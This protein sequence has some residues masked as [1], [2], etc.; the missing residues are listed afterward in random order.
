MASYYNALFDGRSEGNVLEQDLAGVEFDRSAIICAS[1]CCGRARMKQS[2]PTSHGTIKH[3]D[4]TPLRIVAK[5]IIQ[6]AGRAAAWSAYIAQAPR[7]CIGH[8]ITSP[9]RGAVMVR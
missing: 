3:P 8:E 6:P 7:G 2:L 1:K 4:F 9:D 5:N